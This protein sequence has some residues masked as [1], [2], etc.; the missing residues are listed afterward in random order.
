MLTSTINTFVYTI[1]T[2]QMLEQEHLIILE[3][4]QY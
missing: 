4:K 3:D 2:H 1:E